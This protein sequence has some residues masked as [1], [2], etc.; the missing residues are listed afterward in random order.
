M[1]LFE[2]YTESRGRSAVPVTRARTRRRRRRRR[3]CGV[4]I[5]NVQSF[6]GS[7]PQP[8]E[9]QAGRGRR[10]Q[11]LA[12]PKASPRTKIQRRFAAGGG[13]LTGK[14]WTLGALTN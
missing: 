11:P 5:V 2:R 14:D 6:L 12:V 1:P 3:C 13:V 10:A 8:S 7:A 4:W 9:N